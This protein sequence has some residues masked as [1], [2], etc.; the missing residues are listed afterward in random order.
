MKW[1]DKIAEKLD[2]G[3]AVEKIM[4]ITEALESIGEV[5]GD[6]EFPTDEALAETSSGANLLA[7]LG[8]TTEALTPPHEEAGTTDVGELYRDCDF[9]DD[10]TGV[11]L[12]KALTVK[13][14]KEEVSYFKKRGVY[15]KRKREAWMKV[16]STKWF[17]INK[18][19]AKKPNIRCRLVGREL[20][21]EKRD[22]LFAGTPP[23]ESL[24]AVISKCAS[25]QGGKHPFRLLSVDV[26]RAYFYA[27]ATRP[28]F[29]HIPAEDREEGDEG[30][31]AQLNVSFYGTRD[32]PQNWTKTYTD[33]LVKIGF[34]VGKGCACNFHH[35]SRDITLTVHGDDFT[36]AGSTK[37]LEWLRA[38]FEARFEIT[39]H[40]L[41]PEKGQEGEIRILN[42][43]IRWEEHGIAYEPDQRH[44]DIVVR[45]LGL[46]KVSAVNTPGTREQALAA[47][48]P[49]GMP[50]V[51]T[52]AGSVPMV[53]RDATKYR[54]LTAR[55][56][57]LAQDRIDLQFPCKEA[58]RRMSRPCQD[59]WQMLKRIARYLRGAP[60]F[61]QMFEW[62][63]LPASIDIY[64]D[65]DWAGCKSTCRSTSGGVVK[66]GRHCIKSW[67]ST[68]ATV[69]LSSAE[70]ELYALTKGAAQALGIMTMMSDL[71][72]EVSTTVH[73][74]ASAAIGIVRRTGLGKLRHLN[75]RYLWL[76][77]Q[78]KGDNLKL[79][80]VP[81]AENPADIVTKHLNAA[82]S[83]RHLEGLCMKAC[84]GRA[85]S[86]PTV[87]TVCLAS[88]GAPQALD[89][90]TMAWWPSCPGAAVRPMA[91]A[92]ASHKMESE[93]DLWLETPTH[94]IRVHK[95]G[96]SRLFTPPRV[97]GVPPSKALAAVRVT[98]GCY[99]DDGAKF[100]RVDHWTGRTAHLSMARKWTG[101]TS[102]MRVI[103]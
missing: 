41:G 84:S 18:G 82:T 80:K 19:D 93:G 57:Y 11:Q 10:V 32:A 94:C 39:S 100:K 76:Q 54:A 66:W 7:Q 51:P 48:T 6:I 26:K 35:P 99:L 98:E 65:S 79:V 72:A 63:A 24:K 25:R 50:S 70:A 27:P 21:R 60:R 86:A 56:N 85:A 92:D 96:R 73:A 13:A 40:V 67:S 64:T 36:A 23:L 69:A 59:D 88:S 42:R 89:A 49:E 78:L 97:A 9:Y 45:E 30:Y 68:Q 47:S 38:Q 2:I 53:A 15:T 43:V 87:A 46:D 52:A 12:D 71:G 90:Q 5:W 29:I 83:K 103:L 55:L 22:D 28:L 37:E 17:D 62:Q 44:A 61:V 58:S 102:F 34:K 74:D 16:S 8:P 3:D 1:R 14:R 95:T 31:V 91:C 77:D 20:A 4:S 101:T 81:G 75:V 33:F